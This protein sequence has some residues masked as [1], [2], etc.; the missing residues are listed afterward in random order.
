[1]Y[2]RPQATRNKQ[3]NQVDSKSAYFTHIEP[4][5]SPSQMNYQYSNGYAGRYGGDSP[6]PSP[7]ISSFSKP[8][9]L[10]GGYGAPPSQLTHPQRHSPPPP[11]PPQAYGPHTGELTKPSRHRPGRNSGSGCL[12]CFGT[13]ML[14]SVW[15]AALAG[16]AYYWYTEFQLPELQHEV[17]HW[18]RKFETLEDLNA[19]L[20]QTVKSHDAMTQEQREALE[21]AESLSQQVQ[22]LQ[23]SLKLTQ[24][25]RQDGQARLSQV[26]QELHNARHEL[27]QTQEQ[28]AQVQQQSSAVANVEQVQHLQRAIQEQSKLMVLHKYGQG[29]FRV[30]FEVHF[31]Q[32]EHA[33]YF[34]VETAPLHAMPHAV[35]VFL[36]QISSGL[37]NDG[38]FAFHHNGQHILFG[39][40]VPNFI[41][42]PNG[43]P[44]EG[45]EEYEHGQAYLTRRFTE[46]GFGKLAFTEYSPDFPHVEYSL[47]FA[48]R[49]GGPAIYINTIHNVEF[50]GPGGYSADGLGDPCF[51]KVITGLDV[52]QRMH[53]NSGDNLQH[54]DWRE[55]AHGPVAVKSAK[56]LP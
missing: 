52:V 48:G 20:E 35:S 9:N 44:A 27:Q 41:T 46:S 14:L 19:E 2:Q 22:Q 36:D 25:Q 18:Q 23:K 16:G 24:S 39:S 37:Y 3:L 7:P 51:A 8:T 29:P 43:L 1:M 28:L 38:G 50:H 47:A 17:R 5:P 53:A 40:P 21:R 13:I 33:W 49:P 55:M 12:S 26:E 31:P 15:T 11:L 4:P 30:E 10:G 34:V 6:S 56:L 54:D 32:D 42:H 45:G